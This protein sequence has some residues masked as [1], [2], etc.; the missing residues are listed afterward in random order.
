MTVL[1][2]GGDYVTSFKHL[3]STRNYA[4]VE[5]CSGR[6]NGF[7]R[8]QIPSGK[9]LSIHQTKE[10]CCCEDFCKKKNQFQRFH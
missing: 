5:D 9:R 3:I 4:R 8:R 10:D 2:S 7:I 6:K 1:I